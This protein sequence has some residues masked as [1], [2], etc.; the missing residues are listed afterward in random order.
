MRVIGAGWSDIG[1]QRHTNEDSFA[2]MQEGREA[3]RQG[4]CYVVCDGLGGAPAGEVASRL[5]ADAFVLA[6]SSSE[7][8]AVDTKQRL[9]LAV[10]EANTV[11]FRASLSSVA[12]AGMGTTLV[13]LVSHAG[14]AYVC[15][16]GDSRCYRLRGG[17]L[18]QLTEDHT[19]AADMV[20]QGLLDP[21]FAREASERN[22]LTRAVGMTARVEADVT[23]DEMQ[24]GDRYL[25]CSD[26]LWGTVPG[27]ELGTALAG[28]TVQDTVRRLVDLANVYGGPDNAT[29]LVVEVMDSGES[30]G[31][32]G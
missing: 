27:P 8:S 11:V 17:V 5:A 25:L 4:V 31:V 6:W 24:A 9:Q 3:E 20:R 28:G 22:I 32:V 10:H 12:L 23:W 26:G 29:A 13:G 19:L 2:A 18:K 21:A 7:L 15:N 30:S 16:V 1:L 14:W